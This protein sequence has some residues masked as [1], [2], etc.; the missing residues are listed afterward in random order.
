MGKKKIIVGIIAGV[1]VISLAVVGI[2]EI[3]GNSFF[4]KETEDVE[5]AEDED[6]EDSVNDF[7][8]VGTRDARTKTCLANQREIQAQ[9]NNNAMSGILQLQ[10]GDTYELRTNEN[11]TDG[12]WVYT[13]PNNNDQTETVYL[14][15]Q[16]APYCPVD[17]NFIKVTV[18]R[19]NI[20]NSEVE[21]FKIIIECC[22]EH[23]TH[24]RTE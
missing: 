17:G 10:I 16:D 2:A 21:N 18:E 12:E 24:S 7:E 19:A 4:E 13:G 9:F 14:L 8:T 23:E 5:D 20:T 15:F 3:T 22:G 1:L 6:E 11:G